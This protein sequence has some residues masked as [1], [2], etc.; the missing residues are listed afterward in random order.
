[1]PYC[2]FLFF[3]YLGDTSNQLYGL[4]I[5]FIRFID[6]NTTAFQF[7]GYCIDFSKLFSNV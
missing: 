5:E 6:F 2:K 7:Y 3:D 4:L 1:M